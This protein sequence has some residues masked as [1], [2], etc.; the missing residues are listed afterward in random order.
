MTYRALFD[1]RAV[2][3]RF[4]AG[5]LCAVITGPLL[6]AD[7]WIATWQASPHATW[8]E[9]EFALPTG[10]PAVLERQTVRETAR[11]SM[12]GRRVCVVLSNRYGTQPLAIGEARLARDGEAGTVLTFGGQRDVVIPPGAPVVSDALAM[13]VA[14][15]EKLTVSVYLPERTALATFHWGAQQTGAIVEGNQAGAVTWRAAQALHGRAL[16]SGIW[17]DAAA[18][19]HAVAAFGDSITDGNGSTPDRDRR[20]PDYLAARLSA[21]DGGVAV[22]NAGISGAR[23]LGDRM[24]VNAAARFEQD[25][26]AQPGVQTAVVLMGINDIGWPQSVFAPQEAPMTAARMIAVYRQLIAQAQARKVRIIGATLPPFEGTAIA[27]YYTPAKDALR[28]QV[29]QWIRESKE[30]DAVA[31]MDAL[32]RDP[33]HPSRMLP[34]YDSGDHLHP[35]DAGY[36]AMAAAVAEM[37]SRY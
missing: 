33:G 9:Q 7:N 30:F 4:I 14:A 3:K 21:G 25:V 8:G 32:L 34:R 23:L 29:N 37:I 24:G 2:M 17:V 20:W 15:L 28:R 31:D 12:G 19:T 26:L 6:A 22:I 36:E 16:L 27:G 10:V 35:G 13:P 1:R 11:I 5:A 18:P